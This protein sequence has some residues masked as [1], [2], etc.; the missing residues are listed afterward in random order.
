MVKVCSKDLDCAETRAISWTLS[1]LATVTTEIETADLLWWQQ[2]SILW[3]KCLKNWAMSTWTAK[4]QLWEKVNGQQQSQSQRSTTMITSARWRKLKMSARADMVM[5]TSAM[6]STGDQRRVECV[7]HVI[8]SS[9]KLWSTREGV[10]RV[11]WGRFF[12]GDVDQRKTIPMTAAVS[13]SKQYLWRMR[14]VEKLSNLWLAR[15]STWMVR[16]WWFQLLCVDRLKIYPVICLM[17]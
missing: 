14:R 5:M 1:M 10:W 3:P 13:S 2:V 7:R 16:W 4:S 6:S 11:R 12:S 17:S 8:Q 15:S 9:R